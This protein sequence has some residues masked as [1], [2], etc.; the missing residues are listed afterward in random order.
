[1][2]ITNRM[3]SEILKAQVKVSD[4][5]INKIVHCHPDIQW[6][7][8]GPSLYLRRKVPVGGLPFDV[9]TVVSNGTSKAVFDAINKTSDRA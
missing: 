2:K 8:K 7:L 6:A 4:S 3:Q 1:M 9:G 5:V